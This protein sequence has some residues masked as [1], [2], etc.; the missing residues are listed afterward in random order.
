MT[1]PQC[2]AELRHWHGRTRCERDA[3]HTDETDDYGPALDEHWGWCEPC[4][5][6][7]DAAELRWTGFQEDWTRST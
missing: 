6:D 7:G 5:E 3:L 4:L 1:D 2:R